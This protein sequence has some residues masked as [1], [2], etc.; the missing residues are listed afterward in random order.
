MTATYRY[1]GG[2]ALPIPGGIFL[3]PSQ[4]QIDVAST[5]IT[6]SGSYVITM[7]VSD[8]FPSNMTASFTV[9]VTNSAPRLIAKLPN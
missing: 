9:N 5:S 8:D 4:F 1:N 3:K 7:T 2:S 6:D